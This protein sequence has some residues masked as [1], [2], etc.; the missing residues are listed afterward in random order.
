MREAEHSYR[1]RQSEVE[2]PS[3]AHTKSGLSYD[4]R[5]N[6][7]DWVDGPFH[8]RIRFDALPLNF[9]Q[10]KPQLK[11]C[12]MVFLGGYSPTYSLNMFNAFLHFARANPAFAGTAESISPLEVGTYRATLNDS[13]SWR[14]GALNPLLQKWFQLGLGGVDQ[15]CVDYLRVR[16]KPGNTKGA[17][18]RTRDPEHGPFTDAEFQAIFKA[19]GA[20]Y[21]ERS[22]PLWANLLA[23]L[24]ASSGGRPS[25]YAALKI[26]DYKPAIRLGSAVPAKLAL[27]QVKNGLADARNEFLEFDLSEQTAKLFSEHIDHLMTVNGATRSSPVFPADLL[28]PFSREG[29]TRLQDDPFQNHPTG[30]GLSLAIRRELGAIAPVSERTGYSPISLSPRRFRYTFGTRLAEERASKAVIADRLGHTD[31]Q[32]VDVYFE[33]SPCIVDNIDRAM[34]SALA[35]ISLA[36]TGR[37]IA[38][39]QQSTFRGAAGTR[40]IDFRVAATPIG[41]CAK[42][43]GCALVKPVGCYTCHRFEPWLDGPHDEVLQLLLREREQSDDERIASVNDDA[44][45]AVREVI[46]ECQQARQ[47]RLEQE[48]A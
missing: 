21:H 15:S 37:T 17:A 2:L 42:G 48:P 31:L 13:Q 43:S 36:F 41:N 1:G 24:F 12:L 10:F 38:D 44:I 4:P 19:L 11:R 14:V 16:R 39:E 29:S 28:R 25:Q 23:R 40:I 32:N 9:R 6:S 47:Q 5:P 18:V 45:T 33:A 27:P 34:G 8:V 35:P 22:I 46:G 7:W 3:V 30:A 20:A 26:S